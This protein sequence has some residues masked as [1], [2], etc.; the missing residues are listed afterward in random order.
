MTRSNVVPDPDW[1]LYGPEA[2]YPEPKPITYCN[3]CGCELYEG[4]VIYTID[5]GICEECL[6]DR[7]MEYV[8]AED[9]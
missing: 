6:N 5:G 3:S 2:L 4:D 9:E 7:Y 1:K 8:N